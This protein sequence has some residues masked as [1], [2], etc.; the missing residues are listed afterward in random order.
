MEEKIMK[1]IQKVRSI[2]KYNVE[3]EGIVDQQATVKLVE[4]QG[5]LVLCSVSFECY[6][7]LVVKENSIVLIPEFGK[8]KILFEYSSW[9]ELL[10]L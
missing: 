6:D 1:I 8:R 2:G 7:K 9:E 4:V 5:K 3:M 10:D